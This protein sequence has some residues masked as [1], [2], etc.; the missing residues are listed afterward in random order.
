M[1]NIKR[2]NGL[3]FR[4]RLDVGDMEKWGTDTHIE[5]QR[6][7]TIEDFEQ[8]SAGINSMLEG[9]DAFF[10]EEDVAQTPV[11]SRGS[12]SNRALMLCDT[13]DAVYLRHKEA[14]LHSP[15]G[16]LPSLLGTG[17]SLLQLL[18]DRL[19]PHTASWQFVRQQVNFQHGNE[20][21]SS[22]ARPPA[23]PSPPRTAE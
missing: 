17:G 21:D 5:K 20:S 13:P 12:G 11:Q 4:P 18:L 9:P 6:D 7:A 23:E 19:P 1:S 8:I 14:L 10:D 16:P 2:K 22:M 15:H 3:I